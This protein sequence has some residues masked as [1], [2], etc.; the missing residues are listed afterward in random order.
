MPAP[1][2]RVLLV[3]SYEDVFR[4]ADHVQE[5]LEAGPIGLEGMETAI[6]VSSRDE[7]GPTVSF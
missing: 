2:A 3:L 4:A 7:R 6:R 5:V 1:K